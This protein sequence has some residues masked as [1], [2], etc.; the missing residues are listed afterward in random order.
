MCLFILLHSQR[1]VF[2]KQSEGCLEVPKKLSVSFGLR[3][4]LKCFWD[5][6]PINKL[7][8]RL[9]TWGRRLRSW[10]KKCQV[11]AGFAGFA[12]QWTLSVCAKRTCFESTT[13]GP[14]SGSFIFF[15]SYFLWIQTKALDPMRNSLEVIYWFCLY[16]CLSVPPCKGCRCSSEWRTQFLSIRSC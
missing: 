11:P 1:S 16:N 7:F 12:G 3:S 9:Q 14:G 13:S 8:S 2:E 6:Q 5:L 10:Y 15:S 4:C